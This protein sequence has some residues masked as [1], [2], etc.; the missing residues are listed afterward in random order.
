MSTLQ[1]AQDVRDGAIT[2]DAWFAYQILSAICENED[3]GP[4]KDRLA[5]RDAAFRVYTTIAA[6]NTRPGAKP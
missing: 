3:G 5:A 4:S 1:L 6:W 2:Q